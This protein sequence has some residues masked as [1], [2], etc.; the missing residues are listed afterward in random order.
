MEKD[1]FFEGFINNLYSIE[2]GQNPTLK[3]HFTIDED[4]YT[5]ED[6][7]RTYGIGDGTREYHSIQYVSN[8]PNYLLITTAH[9]SKHKADGYQIIYDKTK[10][11]VFSTSNNYSC[12]DSESKY[13]ESPYFIN[14]DLFGLSPVIVGLF[15]ENTFSSY[16]IS[17]DDI[18]D[19]YLKC[20]RELNVL[21]PEKRDELA[22][23]I[24]GYT[25]EELPLLVLLHYK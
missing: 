19:S 2:V 9:I 16:T 13:D 14:N 15:P 1:F 11:E 18:S 12:V 10:K 4:A 6:M 21:M 24:E 25:G 7:K 3:Y 22:D 5:L 8:L 17:M 20:L 23:I